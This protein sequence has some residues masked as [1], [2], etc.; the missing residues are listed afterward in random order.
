MKSIKIDYKLVLG[1]ILCALLVILTYQFPRVFWYLYGAGMLF[2]LSFVIFND[3]LKKEYSFTKGILPGVFS[4]IVLYIV[5]YI[6][7]FILKIMPGGLENSVAAAFNKYATDSWV[8]WLLLV[9]AIIPG[10]EIF[11]RG[12]VLKR[13]NNY[14]NPWFSNIFAALLCM[15]MMFPSG[16]FAAIIGIFVASLV[17]NVMYTYRSSLLMVYVSHLTFAFLLLAA[18]PIY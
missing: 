18:L 4:G 8:I 15:I 6:G 11:W 3:D 1:L 17:W 16:N 14:F 13:L 10:E 5:F 9:V 2:L 12:F 7:A